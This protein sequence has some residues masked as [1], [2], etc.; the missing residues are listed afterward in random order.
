MTTCPKCHR[1]TQSMAYHTCQVTEEMV[2]SLIAEALTEKEEH[3]RKVC[4]QEIR[5]YQPYT[6]VSG[7]ES[8]GFDASFVLDQAR[9]E[10][11]EEA[12]DIV[13]ASV[14]TNQASA[15][16]RSLKRTAKP[17][18]KAKFDKNEQL[19]GIDSRYNRCDCCGEMVD[20][21]DSSWRHAGDHWQH[22]CK[23]VDAQAGHP[24]TA[25]KAETSPLREFVEAADELRTCLMSGW[26]ETKRYDTARSSVDV[27]EIDSI[28]SELDGLRAKVAEAERQRDGYIESWKKAESVLEKIH[29]QLQSEQ[30]E[31]AEY[32]R[33]VASLRSELEKANK[34]LDEVAAWFGSGIDYTEGG[35]IQTWLESVGRLGGAK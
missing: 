20:P 22:R 3:I 32:E 7:A 8:H 19:F 30:E 2:R 4:R 23:G 15:E 5:A 25:T 9:D 11:L 6:A 31:C 28:R 24:G 12:A 18:G 27:E 29:S 34:A 21:M 14:C 33:T 1:D 13:D 35:F 16:I 17:S 10:A 26:D